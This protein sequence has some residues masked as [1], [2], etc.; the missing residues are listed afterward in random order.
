MRVEHK[1][2]KKKRKKR[3][4]RHQKSKNERGLERPTV[5][6]LSSPRKDVRL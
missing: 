3:E 1:K 2:G 5:T 6:F 4:E